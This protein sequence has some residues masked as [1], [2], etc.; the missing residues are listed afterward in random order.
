W[1]PVTSFS[2]QRDQISLF[3]TAARLGAVLDVTGDRR[4]SIK[5]TYGR[6]Y[7]GLRN[8]IVSSTNRNGASFQEW[9]WID[10]NGDR[11]FQ[12]D[13]RGTLRQD[14]R[15][16]L[17]QFDPDLRQPYTD[18]FYIAVDRQIGSNFALSIAGIFKRDHDLMETVDVGRPFSAYAPLT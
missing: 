4:T 8:G 16:N 10:R 17:N 12:S 14:L 2:E 3:T 6:Y 13:E 18:A 9:D 11:V 15:S 5:A 1:F 7:V